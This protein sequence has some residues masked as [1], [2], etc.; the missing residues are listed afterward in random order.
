MAVFP[1]RISTVAGGQGE[2]LLLSGR[3]GHGSQQVVDQQGIA[4]LDLFSPA[5]QCGQQVHPRS[6]STGSPAC[7]R[8]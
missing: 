6:P 7:R 2:S 4:G 8:A 5:I 3:F 1:R